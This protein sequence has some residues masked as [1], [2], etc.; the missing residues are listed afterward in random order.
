LCSVVIIL[1]SVLANAVCHAAVSD[2]ARC[3]SLRQGIV[4]T[5]VCLSVCLS[6]FALITAPVL[7]FL[8]TGWEAVITTISVKNRNHTVVSFFSQLQRHLSFLLVSENVSKNTFMF[9]YW[10]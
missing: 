6:G 10:K 3:T 1:G 7:T 9:L 8:F 5:P 4:L 2:V